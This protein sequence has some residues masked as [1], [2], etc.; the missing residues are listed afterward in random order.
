LELPIP[1]EFIL[2][3]LIGA[4]YRSLSGISVRKSLQSNTWQKLL[5]HIEANLVH[6]QL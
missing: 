6:R 4:E 5:E 2:G 3:N 1:D